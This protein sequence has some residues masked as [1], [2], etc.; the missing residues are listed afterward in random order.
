MI[1]IY[2]DYYIDTIYDVNF[3]VLKEGDIDTLL[4][5]IDNT[6]VPFKTTI[7]DNKVVNWIDLAKKEGF[8][9]CMVSNAYPR[10]AQ[11]ISKNLEI[12]VVYMAKKP[13]K[14]GIIN[15]L[16][17]LDSN[18][19]NTVMIGDQILTDVLAARFARVKSI[20]VEP[21]TKSDFIMT[22]IYRVI[23]FFLKKNLQKKEMK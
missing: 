10:R 16:K 13:F 20:L 9:L 4:L 12:P 23:E 15:A 19:K 22:K 18:K 3:A 2:P 7:A 11:I 14:Q 17:L 21:L 6:L 5:D 1:K 8:K